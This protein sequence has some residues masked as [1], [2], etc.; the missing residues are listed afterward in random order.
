MGVVMTCIR[1]W[2]NHRYLFYDAKSQKMRGG[3]KFVKIS[4]GIRCNHYHCIALCIIH[5]MFS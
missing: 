5:D 3:E 1:L 2:Y 4:L